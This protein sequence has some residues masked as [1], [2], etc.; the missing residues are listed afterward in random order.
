MFI[1]AMNEQHVLKFYSKIRLYDFKVYDNDTLVRNFIPCIRK[2][3]N[4]PG[5]YDL[6]NNEFYT[7]QG[8][9]DTDFTV[10][11]DID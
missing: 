1:F 2:S 9:G 4:K 11:P 5:L 10:G 6:A 3:D 8:T 7:N